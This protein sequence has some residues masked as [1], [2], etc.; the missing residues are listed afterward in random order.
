M[1]I[2]TLLLTA[3]AHKFKNRHR[4]MS[5]LLYKKW[6]K[7]GKPHAFV[8][9]SRGQLYI[10]T[11]SDFTFKTGERQIIMRLYKNYG[12]VLVEVYF[13]PGKDPR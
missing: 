7:E 4:K 8:F 13:E 12:L 9:P 3:E 10:S 2:T 6:K 11:W 5:K 1:R